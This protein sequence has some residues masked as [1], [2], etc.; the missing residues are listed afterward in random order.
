MSHT[1]IGIF[2]SSD[3]AREATQYLFSNGF[4]DS[5]VDIS[6]S[7]TGGG[8]TG[9][10]HS[11]QTGSQTSAS[12]GSYDDNSDSIG[13][14]FDN[15]FSDDKDEAR[16]YSEAGRQ[17]TIVTVHAKSA[18]EANSAAKI[19]DN[20]GAIDV[21]ESTQHNR[22]HGDRNTES[23][24]STESGSIPVIEE[25]M[26]VGKRQKETGGVRIKSRIIERPVEE[27]IRLRSEQV[28]IERNPVN[29]PATEE[30]FKGFKEGTTEVRETKEVPVVNKDS[31]V[32]EEVNLEKDVTENEKTVQGT[33]RKTN[34]ETDEYNE[35]D[36][37]RRSTDDRNRGNDP[38]RR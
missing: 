4:S 20:Y 36:P 16:K 37:N 12:A 5:A 31:R 33:V 25:E 21:D 24:H 35:N 10:T 18:D 30:D 9:G 7:Q 23:A 8:Q 32:V 1:V 27:K 26:H 19:L 34:V 15:L 13:S 6:Y 29:R 38:D 11:A 17:G 3:Q 2:R 28:N 22:S 14:F